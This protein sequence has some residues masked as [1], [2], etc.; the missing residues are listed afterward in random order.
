MR[1]SVHN[2]ARDPSWSDHCSKVS[3]AFILVHGQGM[4]FDSFSCYVCICLLA[5]L[6]LSFV[7]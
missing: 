4:D 2:D 3:C 5:I 7:C 1:I 6:M